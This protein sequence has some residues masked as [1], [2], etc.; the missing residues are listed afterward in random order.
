MVCQPY[1]PSCARPPVSSWQWRDAKTSC[2]HVWKP[3]RSPDPAF[4]GSRADRIGQMRTESQQDVES[5]TRRRDARPSGF[6]RIGRE[7]EKEAD[8]R[9]RVGS[10]QSARAGEVQL[11]SRSPAGKRESRSL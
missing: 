1:A 3:Y 8:T 2:I 7:A 6:A 9:F 4:S 11:T 5:T 10:W